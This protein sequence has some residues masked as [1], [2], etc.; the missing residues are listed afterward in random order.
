[1]KKSI[2]T[3]TAAVGLALLV[4]PVACHR[5]ALR[6]SKVGGFLQ[7]SIYPSATGCDVDYRKVYL[8]KHLGD[9][10]FWHSKDGKT[11]YT[12]LFRRS[13]GSPGSGTPFKD[14]QGNPIYNFPV[15]PTN[16]IKSPVPDQTG[17]FEYSVNDPTDHECKSANDP[18][19]IV[20]D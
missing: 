10:I 1:M 18:G 14:P 6:P 3:I 20:K 12:V 15:D 2:A 19:V 7:V 16:G 4:T 13:D 5:A 11:K 8:E 17:Y 9:R